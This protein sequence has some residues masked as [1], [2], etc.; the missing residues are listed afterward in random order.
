MFRPLRDNILV[1]PVKHE[2]SAILTVVHSSKESQGIVVC[3]GPGKKDKKGKTI[4]TDLKPGDL[5]RFGTEEGYLTYPEI[6]I[7]GETFLLLSE[8]D[9]AFVAEQ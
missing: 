6:Q 3:T 7:K 9:I 1:K 8:K 4:P 5:V 2:K